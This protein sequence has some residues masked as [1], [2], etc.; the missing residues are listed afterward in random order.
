MEQLIKIFLSSNQVEIETKFATLFTGKKDISVKW[1]ATGTPQTNGAVITI[2]PGAFSWVKNKSITSQ[3]CRRLGLP[4]IYAEPENALQIIVR[5]INLHECLHIIHSPF[6]KLKSYNS[7][8]K[9]MAEQLLFNDISNICEDRY[10]EDKGIKDFPKIEMYI[11]Y[12]IYGEMLSAGESFEEDAI[13]EDDII[14]KIIIWLF[15]KYRFKYD[16]EFPTVPDSTLRDK[17]IP[18]SEICCF[19][20]NG[21]KRLESAYNIMQLLSDYLPNTEQQTQNLINI[22]ERIMQMLNASSSICGENNELS[23]PMTTNATLINDLLNETIKQHTIYSKNGNNDNAN[24]IGTENSSKNELVSNLISVDAMGYSDELE[25]LTW[26]YN[27]IRNII[28]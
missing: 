8:I 6:S 27:E 28:A 13:S 14:P 5:G 21:E 2:N 9:T 10:I 26:A 19:D 24:Q 17:I 22:L 11:N 18:L 3:I 23:D 16:E 7:K 1:K 15:K 4:T 25:A 20:D 12:C